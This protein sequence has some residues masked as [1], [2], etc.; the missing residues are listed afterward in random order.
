MPA[1]PFALSAYARSLAG[2]PADR[3]VNRFFERPPRE[4]DQPM[5][6]TRPGLTALATVGTGPI[7]GILRKAGAYDYDAF[8][9]SGEALYRVNAFGVAT[10]LGPIA[11]SARVSMDAS[12]TEVR[13]ANGTS[14]YLYNGTTLT[15]ETFPDSA[16]VVSIAHIRGF[17][18]AV[19]AASQKLF[20]LVPGD[21]VWDA[22]TFVSAEQ[23][24][25]RLTAVVVMGDLVHLF[26]EDTVEEW[27]LTGDPD[28]PLRPNPGRVHEKGCTSPDSIAKGDNT[29]FWVAEDSHQGRAVYRAT[30]GNPE[31][32][33]NHG[34]EEHLRWPG[35][36]DIRAFTF[37]HY[38][39][40][41]YVLTIGDEGTFAYDMATGTWS[42]FKSAGQPHWRAHVG[43]SAPGAL[44]WL[45]DDTTGHIWLLS[46]SEA[47]D[48]GVAFERLATGRVNATGV[49]RVRC[50]R[51]M[52]GASLQGVG[53]TATAILR[54][55][56]DNGVTWVSHGARTLARAGAIASRTWWNRTGMI[57]HPGRIFEVSDAGPSPTTIRGLSYL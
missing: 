32:I 38:G 45:G 25:D 40:E 44:T 21:A 26:G 17:W 13:V 9:V 23:A 35:P 31:R 54:T 20:V 16:G 6:L 34:I 51:V 1:I 7:R 4:N 22:L 37:L 15:T 48:D 24:P 41:F 19:Q 47:T 55:S 27:L 39:H 46:P 57:G 52:L 49:E 10:L 2:A 8:V 53:E 12:A 18:L 43:T 56:D 5:I 30:G 50:N 29:L 14:L 28:P 33:S 11:G 36:L 3:L 42:E